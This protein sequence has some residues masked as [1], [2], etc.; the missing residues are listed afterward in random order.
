MS[1]KERAM[2]AVS[3][4]ERGSARER[5]EH[6]GGRPHGGDCS[7]SWDVDL[8][9]EPLCELLHA[10]ALVLQ[11]DSSQKAPLCGVPG[12]KAERMGFL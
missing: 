6:M 2:A 11:W 5:P 10:H 4:A 9:E 1:C 12:S 7:L 8:E 3:G